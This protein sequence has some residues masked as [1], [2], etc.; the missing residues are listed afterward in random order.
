MIKTFKTIWQGLSPGE[1]K[2]LILG[3]GFMLMFV[4]IVVL[5]VMG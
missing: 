5:G 2:A 1:R 3:G 4:V